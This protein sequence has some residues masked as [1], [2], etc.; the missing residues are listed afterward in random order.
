MDISWTI[1]TRHLST[2]YFAAAGLNDIVFT[3]YSLSNPGHLAPCTLDNAGTILFS[4][5]SNMNLINVTLLLEHFLIMPNI[6]CVCFMHMSMYFMI[7]LFVLVFYVS[8]FCKHMRLSCVYFNKLTYLLTYHFRIA[9]VTIA[10]LAYYSTHS[11]Y[12]RFGD[13]VMFFSE[14]E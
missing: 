11:N 14:H 6:S 2:N 12:T 5:T 7:L 1:Q 10:C 13:V 9:M 8:L 3:T 4:Q